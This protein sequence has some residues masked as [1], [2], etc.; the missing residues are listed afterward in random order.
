M[1]EPIDHV[2]LD[3]RLSGLARRLSPILVQP[4]LAQHKDVF[5]SDITTHRLVARRAGALRRI[6]GSLRKVPRRTVV[7]WQLATGA[8]Q[9]TPLRFADQV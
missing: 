4:A 3:L 2:L 8:T 9:K 6:A 5:A 1:I 7:G